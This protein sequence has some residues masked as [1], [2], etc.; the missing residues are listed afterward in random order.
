MSSLQR[1]FR[2][3]TDLTPFICHSVRLVVHLLSL[4][5]ATCPAHFYFVLVTYWTMSVNLVLCL[6]M[7]S[8][9][10]SFSLTL[11]IFLSIVYWLISSCCFFVFVCLFV[12]LFVFFTNAF[13]RNHL[14]HPYVIAAKTHWLKT[15]LFRLMGR[16][17]S[18]KISLY[19]PKHCML[20]LF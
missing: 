9:I 4:I 12:C 18:R 13:V 10:L 5:R 3:P 7:V 16:C 11:S 19:I 8:W 20:L 17:L 2:L 6:M 1:R 14:W 15:F